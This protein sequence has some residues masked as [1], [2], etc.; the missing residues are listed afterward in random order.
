MK[1]IIVSVIALAFIAIT[2]NAQIKEGSITYV[3]K[4]EGLAPEQ[5]AMMGDM[6]MKNTFKNGKVLTEMNSMMGTNQI[7]IDENGMTMLIDQMGNKIAIKQTKAEMEKESAKSKEKL[8]DPKIEY[9][10]ETKMIA[11][12][13]CKKAII[14]STDKNNKEEKIEMWYCD[15]FFNPNMEGKGKGQN[16]MKGLKGMPFE[17]SGSYGQMKTKITAK[18]VSE[19]LVDEKVFLLSTEG[20]KTMT[21]D[22]LKTMQGGKSH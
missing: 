22:E 8:P 1:K 11:G 19:A 18:E 14:T 15:K 16:I 20:F 3:M 2:A 4:I 9:F 12:Y 10:P 21:M 6:D 5:A 17:Y 7:L 13:E